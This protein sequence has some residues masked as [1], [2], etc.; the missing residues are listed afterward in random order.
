MKR[1]QRLS[2]TRLAAALI[3]AFAIPMDVAFAQQK[4][5]VTDAT[6]RQIEIADSSRIV[7]IGGAV[8]EILYALGLGGRIVA[9]DQTSTYPGEAAKKPNVGYVRALSPEGVLSL[10]PSLVIAVEE[11]GPPAAIEVLRNAR[12]PLVLVPQAHDEGGVLKKIRLVAEAAGMKVEGEALAR[13]VQEDFGALAGLRAAIRNR[14]K[15]AF[16]LALGQGSPIVGGNHTSVSAI[17]TLAGVDNAFATVEG[18]KPAADEAM[19]AAQ[20]DAVVMMAERNH[21][22]T[23]ETVF[24]MPAF[25]ATP[26]AREKKIISLPGLYLLG[27]G[28]R[29]AHAARDLA[30]ALYPELQLAKLPPR[31]WTTDARP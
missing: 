25:A 24:A 21:A 29:T 15:A 8:T 3:L 19:I 7:S 1:V 28:P 14:R 16:V 27:F 13:T 26:A 31:P 6:G 12:V 11:S 20:P 18:F 17:F 22:M 9:I 4:I 2:Q 10:S 23:A 5:S 30:A